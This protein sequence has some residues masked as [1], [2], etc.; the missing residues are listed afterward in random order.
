MKKL[1]IV[2]VLFTFVCNIYAQNDSLK[3]N[4]PVPDSLINAQK[5]KI[6]TAN[7]FNKAIAFQTEIS[8]Q[9][10]LKDLFLAGFIF[11]TLVVIFLFYINNV[12]I[13]QVLE[14]VKIQ[15]RQMEVKNFEVE[16]LSIILNNTIDGIAI[17]DNENNILWNNKSFLELYGMSD[18]ELKDKKIDF[19]SSENKNIQ[20]SINKAKEEKKPVQF[21]FDMKNK[22]GDTIYIQRRIIPLTDKK[23]NIENYAIIDTDYTALKLAV[24]RT[25]KNDT[26]E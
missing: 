24:D 23:D 22:N 18:E 7:T 6:D 20:E 2:V 11:M 8:T 21:S 1:F 25:N 19:F 14:M 16:K 15:E 13:K 5:L 3:I 17:I 9:R 26:K 12:K 10:L 4:S